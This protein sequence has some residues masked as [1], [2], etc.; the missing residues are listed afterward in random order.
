VSTKTA[1]RDQFLREAVEPHRGRVRSLIQSLVDDV[2][3]VDDVYQ[4]VIEEAMGALDVGT[5]IESL[6]A[7]LASVARNKVFDRF[8]RR[9]TQETHARAVRDE[10][11][12]PEE[13]DPVIR[14]WLR[15]EI[16]A[17]LEELPPEQR[18]VFVM[19]ELEGKSFEEISQETGVGVNTLLSRKRYALLALRESLK[20]VYDEFES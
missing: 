4:D 2:A 11:E 17:A 19:H 14:S 9:K 15:S 3:D 18:E 20:E 7:W 8:R 13:S 1:K 16:A 12:A 6:G 10:G 5:A